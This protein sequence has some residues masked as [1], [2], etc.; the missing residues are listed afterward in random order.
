M[1]RKIA[2]VL[3]AAAL[4]LGVAVTSSAPASAMVSDKTCRNDGGWG[5]AITVCAQWDFKV[6][7]DGTGVKSQ[8]VWIDFNNGCPGDTEANVTDQLFATIT[9]GYSAPLNQMTDCHAYRTYVEA[10]YDTGPSSVS[11]LI[12]VNVDNAGDYSLEYDCTLH[13]NGNSSCSMTRV[14]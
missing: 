13:V 7:N 12:P 11:L 6:Q 9:G 5:W 1:K 8:G 2:A 14:N 3:A 4:V 10:G